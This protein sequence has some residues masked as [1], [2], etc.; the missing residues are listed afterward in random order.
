M[1]CFVTFFP[2]HFLHFILTQ[3][4]M[5]GSKNIYITGFM[6]TGKSVTGK[7]LA[8]KLNRFFVD[9]DKEVE[10]ETN[11]AIEDIFSSQGESGFRLLERELIARISQRSNLVVSLGGG[12]ILTAENRAIFKKGQLIFLSTPFQQIWERLQHSQ[13]RPLAKLNF[14]TLHQL[15]QDRLPLYNESDIIIDCAQ[16]DTES[17]CQNILQRIKEHENH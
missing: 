15:Y 2:F 5:A 16:Q 6:A 3:G 12:A 11:L 4:Q 17:I 9:T 8:R 7:L 14:D 10:T 1:T 13:H